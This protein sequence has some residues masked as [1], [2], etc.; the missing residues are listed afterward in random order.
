MNIPIKGLLPF[1]L[2]VIL[3]FS[4]SAFLAMAK[5]SVSTP[6]PASTPAKVPPQA[7]DL[8]GT[9]IIGFDEQGY[10]Y[11][12]QIREV[13]VDPLDPQQEIE[14]YTV[15]YQDEDQTWQNLCQADESFP[16]KAIALQGSWD[17][18]G[19]YV[20]GQDKVS[21]SCVNGALAKCVRM[22][23]KPW[24]S[25]NGIPLRNYHQACVRMVRADYCG[26]GVGHTKNGTMINVYDKLK[27][28]V[29]DPPKK[30]TFEAAWEPNGASCIN[31]LRYENQKEYLQKVCPQ[32]IAIQQDRKN[33]CSSAEKARQN[34]PKALLFNDS[35]QKP[36]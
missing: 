18:T 13:E 29:P 27:I 5:P 11:N 6:I 1:L 2:T 12:F 33:L 9:E 17:R 23:Y 21:F 3:V 28:N 32:K 30:M 10:Q 16:A 20:G 35:E 25:F 15:F 8:I 26:D 31:H 19:A 34:F 7:S 4:V 36:F 14:L 24:K 22:G